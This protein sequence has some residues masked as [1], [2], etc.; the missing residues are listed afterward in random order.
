VCI[1]KSTITCKIYNVKHCVLGNIIGPVHPLSLSVFLLSASSGR[2]DSAAVQPI[3][4]EMIHMATYIQPISVLQSDA[5][6]AIHLAA[7]ASG[8]VSGAVGGLL[9]MHPSGFYNKVI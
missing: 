6:R 2:P 5:E 7:K 9:Y 1:S 8:A 4:D 3:A